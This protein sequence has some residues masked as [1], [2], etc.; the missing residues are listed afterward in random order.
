MKYFEILL[1]VLMA[2][3]GL[4]ILALVVASS[5]ASRPHRRDAVPDRLPEL[6]VLAVAAD[7]HR[8]PHTRSRG[9]DPRGQEVIPVE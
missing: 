9:G 2:L 8:H 4:V 3:A 5:P 7:S 6:P 1:L